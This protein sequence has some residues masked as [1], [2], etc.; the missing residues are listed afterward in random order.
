[1]LDWSGKSPVSRIM[2]KIFGKNP[3]T[4]Y[5]RMLAKRD[6]ELEKLLRKHADLLNSPV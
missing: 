3:M 2:E 5:K 6:G 4:I 1:M